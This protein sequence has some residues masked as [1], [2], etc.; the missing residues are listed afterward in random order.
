MT[1]GANLSKN[2]YSG[3]LNVT[4]IIIVKS[5]MVGGKNTVHTAHAVVNVVNDCCHVFRH[6]T[7]VRYLY[8]FFH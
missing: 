3:Q 1:I 8:M 4:A 2:P 5:E 6:L 7:T